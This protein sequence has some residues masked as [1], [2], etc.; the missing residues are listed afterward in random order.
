VSPSG[1]LVGVPFEKN[2]QSGDPVQ[3]EEGLLV[4]PTNGAKASLSP[5][6]TLA[7]LKGRAQFQPVLVRA[8]SDSASPL[9]S[10]AGVYQNPRFS[11]DG[12]RIAVTVYGASTPDVWVYSLS[13]NTLTRLTSDG[14]NHRPEWTADGRDIVFVSTRNGETG[15][16]QQA[17]DGRSG[18]TL[19]YKPE[20]EPFEAI[21][22]TDMKWLI[23]RTS[24]G[25]KY[26]RDILAVP[27]SGEKTVVPLVTGPTTESQPRPSPDGKWLAYQSSE[28]GRFEVY[29]R[30]FPESGA[31]IQV[32]DNGGSE[33]VWGR[34]GKS[35]FYR[36]A[37]GDVIGV[38]VT[39]G[40]AFSIGAR[41]VVL[42]GNY[43]TDATHA[44][45]DVAPDGRFLM[46]QRAGAESQTVVVH[47]WGRELREK[48]AEKD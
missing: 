30:P 18:A 2:R 48:T 40:T 26:P 45:Y 3:L 32:S 1:D 36:G 14:V 35:L 16:W 24:P 8:G 27:Y 41:S 19:L 31:R 42:R 46:L 15:I 13:R 23:F 28:T 21:V 6:G 33:P 43:L 34:D 39:T 9:I 17:A 4:D 44:S 29:I 5:S 12:D 25:A 10:E 38:S 7:Y 11:P 37:V 47:N 20:I 22:S